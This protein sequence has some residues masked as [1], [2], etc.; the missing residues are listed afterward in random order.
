MRRNARDTESGFTLIE[1]LTVMGCMGVILA[2]AVLASRAPLRTFRVNSAMD[3]ITGQLRS[4]RGMAISQRR[5][6]KVVFT[7]PN[8]IQV[9]RQER[10]AGET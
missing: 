3:Q 4:A 7:S 8:Q 9:C 6:M 5:E 2:M 10:P 1:L